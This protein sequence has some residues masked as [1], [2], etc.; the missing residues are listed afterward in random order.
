MQDCGNVLEEVHGQVDGHVQHVGYGLTLV[1]YLQRLAI[2]AS[3]V[4]HFARH[5]DIGQEV[6][7]DSLV[8]VALT[9]LAASPTDVERETPGFVT[10][11]LRLW[12]ACEEVAYVLEHPGVGSGIGAGGTPQG[13]LVYVDH[14]VYVFQALNAVVGQGVLQRT[15]ES[16]GKDGL[17]GFVDQ[18]RF[19]A[20]RHAGNANEGTQGKAY[21]DV[22][23]VVAPRTV[24]AE[25][26][27]VARAPYGR[28][29]YSPFA[30]EVLRGE[31][32]RAQHFAGRAGKD[33]F[34]PQ[35]SGLGSHVHHVVGS[36][37]HVP[38]M[39][40]H[41]DCIADVAQ[42]LQGMYQAFV[43]ALVQADAGLVQDIE[44]VDQL[45]TYLRGQADALA[46]SAGQTHGGAVQR[47]IVQA[48]IKQKF[49]AGAYFLKYLGCDLPLFTVQVLVDMR[50]PAVQ[51]ADVHRGQL[52]NILVVYPV[53]QSLAV[54]AGSV[55]L[56]T[57]VRPRKLLGP[58]ACRGRHVAVLHHLYVLH[59]AFEGN[60]VVRRCAHQL[61]AYLQPLVRAIQH[62]VEGLVGQLG[63]R[64]LQRSLIT[65]QQGLYLPEY[66]TVL[67]LAQR[68]DGT[69]GYGKRSVGYHLVYV[70]QAHHAQPLA[71]GTGALRRIE[72][73]VMRRRLPIRQTGDGTH[74]P[75]A[76]MPYTAIVLVQHHQQSVALLHG[77]SHGV[78]QARIILVLRH[79]FV[80]DHLHI[81]ILISVQLHA[82]QGLA[83]FAV[84]TYIQIA[85]L[86]YLLE[87]FLIMSFSVTHQRSQ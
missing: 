17:Q 64:C 10:S 7:F 12:Q 61:P 68:D 41:D 71:L 34:A 37:H 43:V 53:G 21:I 79:Q 52:V 77:R 82:R 81:M 87:Q 45:R 38:V 70:Y 4:A 2:I 36:Q 5:V 65:F 59:H 50:Q 22:L 66:H 39:L 3:A 33:H 54:Q 1:A 57:R 29:L 20:A 63:H 23:Q 35:A 83:H 25:S 72:R 55:A 46:L 15:V 86:A 47:K 31:R 14:L 44:H 26:V 74:Q 48:H 19:A 76:V 11:H 51:F 27:P 62:L 58:L 73:E 85:L 56:G 13:R 69:G 40:H 8:S 80:D 32:V 75:L 60:E 18:G 67:V 30:I 78:S 42:F 9:R 49:Q 24:Q 16:L 6:H 28:H 84:H